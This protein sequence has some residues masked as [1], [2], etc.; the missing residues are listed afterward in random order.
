MALERYRERRDFE[1]THEPRGQ[2]R[3]GSGRRFVVQ[4]HAARREHYDF[5]LED[6]GVLKSWAVPKGPSLDPKDKRLAV[7]TEDHPLD[8]GDYEGVIPAGEYGAGPVLLWDRGIW[9]PIGD[10]AEG[11][12]Q[13][14]LKFEL[15]GEKLQGRWVLVRSGS[16]GNW[17]LIKERD[18]AAAADRDIVGEFPRSVK[19]GRAISEL[20]DEGPDTEPGVREDKSTDEFAPASLNNARHAKPP[21]N[22]RPELAT[23]VESPPDGEDWLHEIKYDGYRILSRIDAD[24]VRLL[25]R[26]DKDWTARFPAVAESIQSLALN[27]AV[28]DGE[29]VALR[30]D[31]SSDFQALQNAVKNGADATLAYFVFDLPF[32][33]GYDLRRAPLVQ[34]KQTLRALLERAPDPTMLRYADHAQGHGADF[35]AE[36]C[37]LQLEGLIS[38]RADSAYVSRRARDWLKTKCGQRQE[39]VISGYT[40]PGGSRQGFGSLLLG[41][42]DDGQRLRY[43]GR[44]GTGFSESQLSDLTQRLQSLEQTDSAFANGPADRL[45]G[46]RVHWVRPELVAEVRFGEWTDDGQLRQPSFVSL[47]E[48]KRATEVARE[49]PARGQSH[50]AKT[51]RA[52]RTQTRGAQTK[53]VCGVTLSH[54]ERVLY[55]QQNIT[56]AQLA[57]YYAEVADWML[58]QVAGR[59][60]S[61]VRCPQGQP[62]QC[63]YQKHL[64]DGAPEAVSTVEIA[65]KD[66]RIGYGV[67][68]DAAGLVA[69][70]Q[71]GVL[72]IHPWGARADQPERPDRL[73]FDLDPGEGVAWRSVIQ[74]A[75]E[76]GA[77]LEELGLRS[78]VKSTG[79]KGLHVVAPL[80]RRQDWDRVKAFAGAVAH[81][82][83]A[84]APERYLAKMS[85]AERRGRVFIDYLRNARGATAVAPY[86]TRAREGAPVA[87]PLR[88]DE[89]ARLR[90]PR[91]YT[92]TNLPTR[93]KRLEASPWEDFFDI[94]QSITR[95]AA[96]AVGLDE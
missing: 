56:K 1:R 57:E 90:D 61:L 36:A 86:S 5:R 17:L 29:L 73:I 69:L 52:S 60:L 48:D 79:G 59:P 91:K 58:P 10:V 41:Y 28:L 50:G 88:W 51:S 23:L 42:R 20:E 19:S 6:A 87:T 65:E 89:L 78:F 38:K 37:R 12:R 34:R 80:Q 45:D 64:Q 35:F 76:V 24:R 9:E 70:A 95:K 3:R 54:P 30:E 77:R 11:L 25:S 22:F 15:D 32:L 49:R 26:N 55:P 8:Y 74:A 47:R 43:A 75:R 39:F 68:D 18:N 33:G 16:E 7:E 31:G 72:E 27:D 21:S 40:E 84:E 44:V 63:F 53:T 62:G 67:I 83:A 94:R 82:L 2:E 93:L 13:G 66:Q 4:R 85:K 96:R 81:R 92:L 14:H 71:M 46:R